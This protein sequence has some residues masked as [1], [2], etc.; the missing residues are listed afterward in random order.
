MG[1]K[2]DCRGRDAG[3]DYRHSLSLTDMCVYASDSNQ[4]LGDP[5]GRIKVHRW[6]LERD[7]V[8]VRIRKLTPATDGS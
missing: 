6:E 4:V 8:Q 2:S 1:G 7:R 5:R 3:K